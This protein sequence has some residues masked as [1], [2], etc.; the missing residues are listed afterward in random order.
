[1][2]HSKLI[3]FRD[4]IS[5]SQFLMIPIQLGEKQ[6]NKSSYEIYMYIFPVVTML[7]ESLHNFCVLYSFQSDLAGTNMAVLI[8][9]CGQRLCRA[10][11][12]QRNPTQ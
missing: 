10:S 3:Y 11:S 12:C 2:L 7:L 4:N 6:K 5:L 9:H 1:M 8:Q